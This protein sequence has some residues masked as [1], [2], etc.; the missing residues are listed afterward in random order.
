MSEPAATEAP[1]EL[2]TPKAAEQVAALLRRQ[3]VAG[4]R[5]EGELLPPELRLMTE[6]GVSRPTLRQALRILEN[7]RL[8]RIHRGRNGGA[9]VSRPSVRT[10]ERHLNNLLLYQ[11]AT[12]DD[13][14]TARL[15]LE[16]AA[17]AR[18]AGTVSAEGI[19]SLRESVAANLATTDAGETRR[20]GS[21]FH[22]RLVELTGNR[23]L[24]LFA[25]LISGLL[26]GA[27]ARHESERLKQREPSRSGE[28]IA[29]HS[30]IID[31]I[32]AGAAREAARHWREHLEAVHRQLRKTINTDL[33]LDLE[34]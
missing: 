14:H 10:A 30:R 11:G 22:I 18:L 7:E 24:V 4:E 21:E 25:R 33:V 23:S 27:L 32:E 16:P 19:A 34:A 17:V 5:A 28:L 13:V 12:L 3:I 1:E 8:V 29:D 15:L 9:R 31:L 26:D 6:L 20:I 2:P